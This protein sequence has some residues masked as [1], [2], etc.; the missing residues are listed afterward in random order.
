VLN[1]EWLD[2]GVSVVLVWFLFALVVS[3]INESLVALLAVRSKQLWRALAQL[4]DGSEKPTGLLRS[5]AGLPGWSARPA[6]P[7]PGGGSPITEK[8]YATQA[9]QGLENRTARYQKTRIQ[10]I[11]ASV[12]SHAVVELA[13]TAPGNEALDQIENYVNG[14]PPDLPLKRQLGA[15]LAAAQRDVEQFRA[16]VERWFDGQMSRLTRLYRSQVRVLLAIIA[17]AVAVVGFG[18]GM[19]SDALRLVTDLQQDANLRSL[20]I[21]AA[22]EA[23]KTDLAKA[24]GCDGTAA[25]NSA[26]CQLK[27]VRSLKSVDLVF[28]G[29]GPP[30][31]AGWAERVGFLL[32]WRHWLAFLGVVITGVAISFGSSFWF[33]VLKRVVGLRS[34]GQ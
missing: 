9:I 6:D 33:S 32:P 25:S 20:V 31:K 19:R 8:L 1:F 12:F 4:M 11:P 5:L 21:G 3:A 24:G 27:G 10:N 34:A 18:F 14:L 22:T 17:V 7:N 29:G 13:L 2:I 30:A 23:A 16:G 15:L 26:A 28:H